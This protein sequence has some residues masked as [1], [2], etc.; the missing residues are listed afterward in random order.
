[1]RSD[2]NPRAALILGAVLIL[3]LERLVP[4]GRLVL[5]PFT[6]LSTWV[7]EMGHGVTALLCG[8]EFARLDIYADAS[9][10]AQTAVVPGVRQALIAAGGLL[11]PP[12][13]GAVCLVLAQRA[14][15]PLLYLLCGAL[16]VSLPLWVRTGV[17]WLSVGGLGLGLLLLTRLLD[18]SGRLFLAQFIGLLLALDTLSRGDYLFMESA[19]VGGRL[20]LSDVAAIARVMHGPVVLW[21][22][23]IALISALLVGI[24]LYSV[25]RRR[26][27]PEHA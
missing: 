13:V 14:A 26:A 12:L 17:G 10:I 22:G 19:Q 7:H 25:L 6:L 20:Q 5:Y 18:V 27:R 15:R 1:M 3:V 8:G 21:G 24:G 11:G 4:M 23:F 2:S 16:L 9:G